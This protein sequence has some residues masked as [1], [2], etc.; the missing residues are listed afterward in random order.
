MKRTRKYQTAL[1]AAV[2]AGFTFLPQA[3][4]ADTEYETDTVK[5]EAE[6]VDKYLVTTNTITAEEIADRGYRDLSDILSQVPGLYMAPAAKDSKMVRVRGASSDQ[7]KVYI[8]GIPAFPLT[9]IVSNAASDLSTIPADSIA[10]VEIIKGSGPVQYGTDYKGGVI[11]ITTKDGKGAGKFRVSAAGGSNH[12]YD[13]KIGYSGSDKNVSYAVNLSKRYSAGYLENQMDKK[14]YFDGK[15]SF[16]TSSKST[17]TLNGY[18]SDMEREIPRSVDPITGQYEAPSGP[19]WSVRPGDGITKKNLVGHAATDWRFKGFKQSNIALQYESRPNDLWLYNVKYYHMI[20]ENNLWIRNLLKEEGGSL[21]F[22]TYGAP[23]WYRSGWFSRGNGIEAN[24]LVAYDSKNVLSFGAKY[25][26]LSWNTDENNSSYRRD[27]NDARR[28]FYVENAWS[29]DNRTRLTIGVRREDVT[30]DFRDNDA[31]TQKTTSK[32]NAFDPVLN[33][34]HDITK[35]DTIR[36]SAGRSHVFVGSKDAAGNIR[37]GYPVPKPERNSSYELGWKHK[38]GTKAEFDLTHFRT[39]VRDRITMVRFGRDRVLENVDKTHIRGL[40]LSYRQTF[41]SKLS[42]FANYTWINAK[43]EENGVTKLA[44][45]LPTQMFNL[46]VTYR[47]GKLRSTLLGRAMRARLD[48][49]GEP[50]SAGYFAA[51]LDLRYEPQT[52]L[53]IFLRVNN[54]FDTDYQYSWGSPADGTNFLLGVDMTF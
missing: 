6:G 49:N 12:T 22:F 16:K 15:I 11:L 23:Q 51:D 19:R 2:M 53:G 28:S 24:A 35:H 1:V 26:K 33:F 37:S 17:L 13:T 30:Q 36:L 41:S 4:A 40:E 7:T 48:S 54:L 25:I 39:E 46:G 47:E 3:Y 43:D 14:L 5:V 52:D 9:G 27:G 20:D 8:D 50:T 42:A 44:S 38:F 34:T 18:Y 10:K 45:G 32:S 29:P 31:A 21:P